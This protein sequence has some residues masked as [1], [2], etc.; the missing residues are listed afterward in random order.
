MGDTAHSRDRSVPSALF[1]LIGPRTAAL[2]GACVAVLTAHTLGVEWLASRFL[3]MPM[4]LWVV[5]LVMLFA[6]YRHQSRDG[7]AG[8]ST[9]EGARRVELSKLNLASVNLAAMKAVIP[10]A[11]TVGGVLE[12]VGVP[13]DSLG[14]AK[15]TLNNIGAKV[16]PSANTLRIGV[17]LADADAREIIAYGLHEENL[18]VQVEW[19]KA[20]SGLVTDVEQDMSAAGLD[21]LIRR[22]RRGDINVFVA[23]QPDHPAAWPEWGT[24]MALGYAG[25]FPPRID[26][27][28]VV[29]SGC[30]LQQASHAELAARMTIACA[31]LARIPGRAGVGRSAVGRMFS[32]RPGMPNLMGEDGPLV[33]AVRRV[34]HSLEHFV[35]APNSP[36]GLPGFVRA[37]ARACAAFMTS[38]ESQTSTDAT[39]ATVAI[40]CRLTGEEPESILRLAAA[41]FADGQTDDARCTL[42][43]ACTSL[44]TF[45]RRCDTDPLPF[46]MS[47]VEVG[48]PG[49]MALGR[50]AAGIGLA[51][52]TAP[53]ETIDYLREDLLDDLSH[54]GWLRDR[55]ADVEMLKGVVEM[56]EGGASVR[57]Q[58]A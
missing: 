40:A 39:A 51:W 35:N 22:E 36:S 23:E 38:T 7:A 10:S 16:A 58:A 18:G 8:L 37:A 47:E 21:V 2:V 48:T 20:R 33:A 45:E 29:L 1:T 52:A 49:R 56:L 17:D 43:R 25:V 31:M 6:Q 26:P 32:G 9:D 57:L 46:I 30:D 50:V 11:G 4:G 12:L 15:R 41:Q 14:Q 3:F 42:L 28:R 13:A 5:G 54:A 19:C 27:S 53:R 34:G 44:R 55:P 24:S